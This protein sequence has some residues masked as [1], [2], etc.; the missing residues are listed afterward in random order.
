MWDD[1]ATHHN[2]RPDYSED[3]HRLIRRC[4]VMAD[5][6]FDPAFA[7]RAAL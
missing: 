7:Q 6:L 3:E 1:I 5:R 4:Q 2:A